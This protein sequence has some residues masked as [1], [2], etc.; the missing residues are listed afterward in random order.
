[1]C[2]SFRRQNLWTRV[3]KRITYTTKMLSIVNTIHLTWDNRTDTHK[4]FRSVRVILETT[5]RLSTFQP[6]S[7]LPKC[8]ILQLQYN[9]T[10]PESMMTGGGLVGWLKLYSRLCLI[11][12]S[13]YVKYLRRDRKRVVAVHTF[14]ENGRNTI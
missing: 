9:Y 3:R 12:K 4:P 10:A 13:N 8:T 14:L 1:M 2:T 11:A 6:L 5:N 7:M